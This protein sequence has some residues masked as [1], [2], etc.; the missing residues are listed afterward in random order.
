MKDNHTDKICENGDG[1]TWEQRFDFFLKAVNDVS[2]A[3]NEAAQSSKMLHHAIGSHNEL[4]TAIFWVITSQIV[5]NGGV[6][7]DLSDLVCDRTK[8]EKEPHD[9]QCDDS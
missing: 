4:L 2:K 6:A 9:K 5:E 7:P 1:F 8:K 3:I